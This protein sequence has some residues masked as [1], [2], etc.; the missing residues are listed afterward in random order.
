MGEASRKY[1]WVLSRS[2]Q[3]EGGIY[4]GIVGRLREQGFDVYKLERNP[5]KPVEKTI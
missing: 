3:M 5:Q 1:L 2:P 4:D